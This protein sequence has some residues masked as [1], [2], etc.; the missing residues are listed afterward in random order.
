[1]DEQTYVAD[2]CGASSLPYWK[3]E[4][5]EI[6]PHLLILREDAFLRAAPADGADE[7]YFKLIHCMK[8]LRQPTLDA[9]F[10]PAS[11]GIREYA[12][13]IQQ[14]YSEGCISTEALNTTIRGIHWA[15]M[16]NAALRE[17]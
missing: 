13:H 11:P 14:C 15:Y 10:V 4:Q 7:P 12:Q 3:T 16:K 5:M 2:P 1:M 8:P 9:R 6:P 17:K